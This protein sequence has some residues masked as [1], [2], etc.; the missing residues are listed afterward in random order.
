MQRRY[1]IALAAAAALF[2]G[3]ATVQAAPDDSSRAQC[4]R[5]S[6][7]DASAQAAPTRLNLRLKDHRYIQIQTKGACFVGTGIPPYAISVQ[8]GGDVAC[9]AIEIE[10][11]GSLGGPCLVD[12]ITPLTKAQ[13]LALPKREQP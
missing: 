1:S 4:F 13:V 10:L 12:S 2:A 7:I 5:P 8:G 3:Q 9:H 6:D 11:S